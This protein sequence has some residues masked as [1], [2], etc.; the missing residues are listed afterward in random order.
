MTVAMCSKCNKLI[1]ISNIPGGNPIAKANPD[2]WA[3]VYG[4]CDMCGK[5]YCDKCL[6]ENMSKCPGCGHNI[7]IKRL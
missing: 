6:E 1:S 7:E 5:F 3:M 4:R 2:L